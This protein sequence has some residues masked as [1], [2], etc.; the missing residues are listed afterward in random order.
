MILYLYIVKSPLGIAWYIW[1]VCLALFLVILLIFDVVIVFP[2]ETKYGWQI[3]P[4]WREFQVDFR[5]MQKDVK[6]IKRKLGLGRME[7]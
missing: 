6:D 4:E 7:K 2:S 1:V 5:E 3:N